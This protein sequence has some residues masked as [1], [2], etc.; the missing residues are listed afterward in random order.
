MATARDSQPLPIDHLDQLFFPKVSPWGLPTSTDDLWFCPSDIDDL[1]TTFK[2]S[3]PTARGVE[4]YFLS[5]S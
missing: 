5:N 4:S 1:S 2:R 3:R